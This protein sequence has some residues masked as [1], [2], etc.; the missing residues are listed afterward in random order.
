MPDHLTGNK[1][2]DALLTD[3][4]RKPMSMSFHTFMKRIRTLSAFVPY[5]SG[6]AGELDD[7]DLTAVLLRAV[8]KAMK[9]LK[10]Q[11]RGH[12]G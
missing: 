11:Q 12:S 9:T 8:P 7:V 6:N 5:L 4:V 10:E 1:L 3:D 2:R